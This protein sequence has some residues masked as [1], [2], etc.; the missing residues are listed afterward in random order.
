MLNGY[1]SPRNQVVGIILHLSEQYPQ[2][3]RN[4][5]FLAV[6]IFDRCLR[7]LSSSNS[8]CFWSPSQA[9]ALAIA[10]LVLAWKFQGD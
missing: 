8:F 1:E 3:P 4:S 2:L 6:S 9:G 5:M 10:A 7:N